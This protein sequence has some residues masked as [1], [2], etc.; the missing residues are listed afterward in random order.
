MRTC[1][2]VMRDASD[3]VSSLMI[4]AVMNRRYIVTAAPRGS[5][6]VLLQGCASAVTTT[7]RVNHHTD[8]SA[9]GDILYYEPG[10]CA[11]RAWA[12]A[13]MTDSALRPAPAPAGRLC[14]GRCNLHR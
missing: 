6:L 8:I 7:G 4:H 3:A 9:D 13:L 11:S 10:A 14:H 5:T 1:L 2:Y 12:A